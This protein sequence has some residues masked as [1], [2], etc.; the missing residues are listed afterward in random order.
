MS[1]WTRLKAALTPPPAPPAPPA[2]RAVF[3]VTP[4]VAEVNAWGT[5]IRDAQGGQIAYLWTPAEDTTP[6]RLQAEAFVRLV[7]EAAEAEAMIE[8]QEARIW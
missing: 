4:L 6:A 3:P 8:A 1:L 5:M 7:N 2:I